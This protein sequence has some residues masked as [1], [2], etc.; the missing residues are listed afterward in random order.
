MDSQVKGHI[1]L[2]VRYGDHP[3]PH[4]AA[5]LGELEQ[6]LQHPDRGVT[7]CQVDGVVAVVAGLIGAPCEAWTVELGKG[8]DA[9]EESEEVSHGEM[10]QLFLLFC[11][12]PLLYTLKHYLLLAIHP[13]LGG[14]RD[15]LREK[16]WG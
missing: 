9:R 2:K 7:C 15:Q 13:L 4:T 11:F 1:P 3:L 12:L 16:V 14:K 8:Y 5:A 10:V 6:S